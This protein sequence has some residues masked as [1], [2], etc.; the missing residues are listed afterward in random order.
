MDAT[1]RAL[2]RFGLGARSDERKQITDPR[3][4]LKAQLD[5]GPPTLRA[6][7]GASPREIGDAIARRCAWPGQADEQDKR[8]ARRTLVEL[9]TSEARPRW[10]SA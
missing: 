4:W 1:L 5:G 10:P 6:P 3:G 9:G 8:E 2:N 7:E